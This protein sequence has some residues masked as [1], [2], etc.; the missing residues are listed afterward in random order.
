MKVN[1]KSI[2]MVALTVAISLINNME[3][4]SA[5]PNPKPPIPPDPYIVSESAKPTPPIPPDPYIQSGID[6][7]MN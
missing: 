7:S 5:K 1:V 2:A 6:M 3:M 4:G